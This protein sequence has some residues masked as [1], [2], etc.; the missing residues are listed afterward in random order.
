MRG[1]V[2]ELLLEECGA[3]RDGG[4]DGGAIEAVGA[5]TL[6]HD[7]GV[8]FRWN[9]WLQC[10]PQP[11]FQPLVV[12]IEVDR[13]KAVALRAQLLAV[14]LQGDLARCSA[15]LWALYEEAVADGDERRTATPAP[16]DD[17]AR[18]IGAV[19]EQGARRSDVAVDDDDRRVGFLVRGRQL[20]PDGRRGVGG[21]ETCRQGAGGC[22]PADHCKHR[23]AH[24]P[25]VP[26]EEWLAE[27]DAVA[28]AQVGGDKRHHVVRD[29]AP[30]HQVAWSR[31][32]DARRVQPLQQDLLRR[33]VFAEGLRDPATADAQD[34][35]ITTTQRRSEGGS[36][37]HEVIDAQIL[38]CR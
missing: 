19:G 2:G 8:V 4:I 30:E 12:R 21:G 10:G 16:R 32:H 26:H 36:P 25:G 1:V 27:R 24:G 9:R 3:P 20:R 33:N 23:N 15:R 7:A 35:R 11:G 29:Q 5:E 31:G 17:R 38:R 34:G 37:L 28:I 18:E 14:P 13:G 22:R 6:G